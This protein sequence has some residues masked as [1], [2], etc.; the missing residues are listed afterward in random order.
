MFDQVNVKKGPTIVRPNHVLVWPGIPLRQHISST[1]PAWSMNLRQRVDKKSVFAQWIFDKE[2]QCVK[3]TVSNSVCKLMDVQEETE[4]VPQ[5]KMVAMNPW[6]GG[7]FNPWER[8]DTVYD[9]GT[10]GSTT[11]EEISVSCNPI[12][13][14]GK[15]QK[16]SD[17]YILQP[18]NACY[19]S[20]LGKL[21][22][23]VYYSPILPNN[24]VELNTTLTLKRF[25]DECSIG[26]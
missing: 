13:C 1:L 24:G 26:V 8:C 22:T 16:T 6:L 9:G 12:V 17:Y 3:G 19:E 7:D 15:T 10:Q 21:V 11:N 14:D 5:S 20:K 23:Q 2:P 4:S 18:N 25:A